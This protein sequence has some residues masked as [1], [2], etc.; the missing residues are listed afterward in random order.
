MLDLAKL[1]EFSQ[2][3]EKDDRGELPAQV[4]ELIEPGTSLGG[5]R[6]KNVVEDDEGLWIAKFPAK[7]DRWSNARVECAM[8]A[9]ARECGLRS[10]DSPVVRVADA[11]ILL[12][13]RFDR[14]K[15]KGGYF[16]EER[17]SPLPVRFPVMR[18]G[19]GP[20]VRHS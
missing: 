7:T 4:E 19:T 8:L 16:L 12:V 20:V 2:A 17:M 10:C 18:R 9:L 5:A 15:V 3:A 11:E 1:L 13:R 6:P 14:I